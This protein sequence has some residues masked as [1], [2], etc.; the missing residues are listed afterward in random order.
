M[1]LTTI[2]RLDAVGAR[3]YNL[4]MAAA[5]LEEPLARP[6]VG[7]WLV[8]LPPLGFLWFQW[9][10]HLR[11]E[12]SVNPQYAYGWAVPLLAAFLAWSGR[13]GTTVTESQPRPI[14]VVGW[15]FIAGLALLWLP[16]RLVAEANP[17]WRLVSWAL[18]LIAVGLTLGALRLTLGAGWRPFVFPVLFTLVAVPWPTIVEAPLI[19]ALTGWNLLACV[20]ILGWLGVPAMPHGNVIEIST[21]VVGVEEACSGIRSFQASLMIALFLGHYYALGWRPRVGLIAAGFGLSLLFNVVRTTLLVWVASRQGLEAIANWHDPAGVPILVGCFLGVWAVAAWLARGK[22]QGAGQVT[23]AKQSA[24]GH[25]SEQPTSNLQPPTPKAVTAGNSETVGSCSGNRAGVAVALL[26]WLVVAE[27]AVA[28][29]FRAHEREARPQPVWT[30]AWPTNAPGFRALTLPEQNRRLLR[31][32][33]A[34]TAQWRT[35]DGTP[36]Q[37]IFLRWEPGRVAAKLA[38][39]HTPEVCLTA[40]GGVLQGPPRSQKFPVAGLDLEFEVYDFDGLRAYYCLW[41][42]RTAAQESSSVSLTYARRWQAVREGRRNLGQRSLE[43]AFWTC[44]DAAETDAL[45]A[46]L[47]A[48]LVQVEK[49]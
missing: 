12:W 22:G 8:W 6:S 13:G 3:F 41:A 29:W 45:M 1:S 28:L 24:V 49:P 11:L 25:N 36:V 7:R 26:V 33:E 10:N 21:G 43:V 9:F 15:L 23:S 5:A 14:P 18:A 39:S 46:A 30:V 27:T 34:G 44:A 17:D 20:E 32:D 42:D 38:R 47:L 35:V 4:R 2:L 16:V 19:R 48:E 37:A 31:F 40:A